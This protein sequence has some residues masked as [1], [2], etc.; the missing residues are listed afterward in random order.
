MY[1]VNCSQ[2]CDECDQMCI[3]KAVESIVVNGKKLPIVSGSLEPLD[4]AC[5]DCQNNV[6]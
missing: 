6:I 3:V 4:I 1:E 5:E 2:S